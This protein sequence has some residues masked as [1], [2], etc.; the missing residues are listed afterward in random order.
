V[1]G[2]RRRGSRYEGLKHSGWG[3]LTNRTAEK[4]RQA[5]RMK[6]STLSRPLLKKKSEGRKKAKKVLL[7]FPDLLVRGTT[8]TGDKGFGEGTSGE[9]SHKGKTEKS[10]NLA[11]S[12]RKIC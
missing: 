5:L 7:R 11:V 2:E 1:K 8:V 10:Q 9:A 3:K 6:K 4:K 12:L